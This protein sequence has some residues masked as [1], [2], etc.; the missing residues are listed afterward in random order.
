[1]GFLE[2]QF[3][4]IFFAGPFACLGSIALCA[5][6]LSCSAEKNTSPSFA[7]QQSLAGLGVAL[8][9]TLVS[10]FLFVRGYEGPFLGN[11][12]VL[13]QGV[14]AWF[15]LFALS[16]LV[17]LLFLFFQGKPFALQNPELL[18]A[19]AGLFFF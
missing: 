10:L 14:N 13:S 17:A 19:V 15:F 16:S 2:I 18:P 3:A 5:W 8:F 4:F 11:F 6:E 12:F 9:G 7:S 1:M